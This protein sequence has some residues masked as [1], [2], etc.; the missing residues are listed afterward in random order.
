M[1]EFAIKNLLINEKKEVIS[2]LFEEF[3]EELYKKAALDDAEASYEDGK[4]EGLK[5]EK[6][7]VIKNALSLNL[8]VED[9]AKLTSLSK[10]E[11][12]DII[13]SVAH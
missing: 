2:M 1:T 7:S 13:S 9:I 4:K 6:I 8:S 11:V 12:E 5:S 3:N 10:K